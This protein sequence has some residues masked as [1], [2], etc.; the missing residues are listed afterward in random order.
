[1]IV[2]SEDK[3]INC[4]FIKVYKVDCYEKLIAEFIQQRQSEASCLLISALIQNYI[5]ELNINKV[6]K[7]IKYYQILNVFIKVRSRLV[8]IVSLWTQILVTL[9]KTAFWPQ[10]MQRLYLMLKMGVSDGQ[11]IQ[12]FWVASK[13]GLSLGHIANPYFSLLVLS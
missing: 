6:N 3:L 2:G 5:A 12:K 11:L 10:L 7:D 13:K 1:M 4:N 9:L 8:A